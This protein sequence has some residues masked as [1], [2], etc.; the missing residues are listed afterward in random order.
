MSF[1][2]LES[3]DLPNSYPSQATELESQGIRRKR[4][5]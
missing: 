3:G 1:K 2:S 4:Q 5:I